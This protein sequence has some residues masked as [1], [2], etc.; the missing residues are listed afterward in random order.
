MVD[1][2]P[3]LDRTESNRIEEAVR[4]GTVLSCRRGKEA[5][6]RRMSDELI[7]IIIG[8]II[9]DGTSQTRLVTR[10]NSVVVPWP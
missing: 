4:N 9:S 10:I 1:I 5:M 6:Y 7:N 8:I 2:I 3:V